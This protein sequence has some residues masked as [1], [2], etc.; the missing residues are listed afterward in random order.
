MRDANPAI[1]KLLDR[2][3]LAPSE[4]GKRLYYFYC[5]SDKRLL[6]DGVDL[7]HDSWQ[8]SSSGGSAAPGSGDEAA[9]G[10][11]LAAARSG[12]V[13]GRGASIS[14]SGDAGDGLEPVPEEL[15]EQLRQYRPF[16]CLPYE[17]E[18]GEGSGARGSGMLCA[19]AA[20]WPCRCACCGVAAPPARQ[21]VLSQRQRKGTN[22]WR[23]SSSH[24]ACYSAPQM[25]GWLMR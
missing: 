4:L 22:Q 12:S 1:A 2:A 13:N 14:G 17:Q 19:N 10:D 24:L 16:A 7:T 23:S 3:E 15:M 5:S 9:S 8:R 18:T 21:V 20:Q 11:E 6:M 25:L